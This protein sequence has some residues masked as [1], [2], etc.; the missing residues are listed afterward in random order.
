MLLPAPLVA[1][2]RDRL[3]GQELEVEPV[4][5]ERRAARD[6]RTRRPRAE[7]ARSGRAQ[8]RPAVPPISPR[9]RA[10]RAAPSIRSAT[11]SPSALAWNC[12]PSW[13]AAVQLGREHEHGQPGLEPEAAADEPHADR[14]RDERDAERGGQLEHRAREEADAQRAHRGAPVAL[15]RRPSIT[16]ACARLRL[17]ARSVGSPRTT[18]RKWVEQPKRRP[19]LARPLAPC[20]GRSAT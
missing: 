17:N 8:R 20:S 13:R 5:D 11:A 10:P 7:R 1:D 6:T 14:D 4:E 19:A 2:E 9:R 16:A 12:A 15:A 18:S 3:A